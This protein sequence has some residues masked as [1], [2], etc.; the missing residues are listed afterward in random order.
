M[1][2]RPTACVSVIL[3]LTDAI[4]KRAATIYADLISATP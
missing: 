3:P 2:A 4:D 1:R